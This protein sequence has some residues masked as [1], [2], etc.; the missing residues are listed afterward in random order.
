M[1]LY[2]WAGR[3]LFAV[4]NPDGILPILIAY[5]AFVV[6]LHALQAVVHAKQ[7][8]GTALSGPFRSQPLE[9]TF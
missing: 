8:W 6:C 9:L 5:C 4:C 3:F 7:L 1:A 2:C